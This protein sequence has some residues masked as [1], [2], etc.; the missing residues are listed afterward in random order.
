MSELLGWE[1]VG[2]QI[3]ER[4]AAVEKVETS[5]AE[6]ADERT[7]AWW[8]G[9]MKGFNFRDL[10]SYSVLGHATLQQLLASVIQEAARVGKCVIIRRSSQ[11]VLHN[12]PH[13]LRVL[14]YAPLAETLK[15]MNLRYPHE[16]DLE[17]LP[18]AWTWN[19]CTMRRITMATIRCIVAPTISG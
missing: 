2:K 4:V 12:D 7:N 1:Y 10:E 18:T 19:G 9:V 6:K 11:C 14:V 16:R 3:I 15:R 13:A 5:R 17:T 8:E